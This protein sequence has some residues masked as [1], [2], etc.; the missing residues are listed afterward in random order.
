MLEAPCKD[1]PKKGCGVYHDKCPEYQEYKKESIRIK[2][3]Q[4]E[5]TRFEIDYKSMEIER[6]VKRQKERTRLKQR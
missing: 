4:Q 5:R 6:A 2:E 3:E 1:C